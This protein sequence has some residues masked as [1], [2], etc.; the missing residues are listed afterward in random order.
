MQFN[1]YKMPTLLMRRNLSRQ[2]LPVVAHEKLIFSKTN[3]QL[4][5]NL[6]YVNI[7]NY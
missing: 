5:K 7:I 3:D 6:I 4:L 2:S 1:F